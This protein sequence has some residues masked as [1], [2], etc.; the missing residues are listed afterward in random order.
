M[1]RDAFLGGRLSIAQPE[2]GFR[3]GTDSV[4]L[5]AAVSPASRTLL[6]IG[7]GV[8]TAAFVALAYNP[9]LSAVLMDR[10][11][12]LVVTA[13][14][15]IV[16][17]Q[18]EERARATFCDVAA[19]NAEREARG[20]RLRAFDSVIANPPYFHVGTL[21]PEPQ[22]A[23]SRHMANDMLE[24]W[25]RLASA[26]VRQNGEALF[27]YPAEGLYHLLACMQGRFGNVTV[28]PIASRPGQDASRVLVRG[29]RGSRAPMRIMTPLVLH[30]EDGNGFTPTVEA[31]LRGESRL[32][33]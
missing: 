5:G 16:H 1:T 6:D 23:T 27:I 21:A 9:E 4:L 25:L 18:M 14:G 22:R 13:A 15:N 32:V 19:P 17:N 30:G 11:A 8:G 10:D 20:V 2:R 3:A 12:D 31:I 26:S 28:M 24:T 33:W 7:C 29:T